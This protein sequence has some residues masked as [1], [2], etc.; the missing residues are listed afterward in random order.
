MRKSNLRSR[1]KESEAKGCIAEVGK[2]FPHF[3]RWFAREYPANCHF[4]KVE[5]YRVLNVFCIFCHGGCRGF[6]IAKNLKGGFRK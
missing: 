5:S 3:S 4:F 6:F 2:M 1:G